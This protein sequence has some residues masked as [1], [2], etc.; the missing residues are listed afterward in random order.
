MPIN[1]PGAFNPDLQI[2]IWEVAFAKDTIPDD[3]FSFMSGTVNMAGGKK[4]P[5]LPNAIYLKINAEKPKGAYEITVPLVKSLSEDPGLGSDYDQ[6]D[7]EE[8]YKT[9]SWSIQYTDV[10]H[11]TVNQSY[12]HTALDTFPYDL[13]KERVPLLTE[14]FQQYRGKE[15][16]QA[17]IEGQSENLLEA[18]VYND[19]QLNPNWFLPNVLE[20]DQPVYDTNY[21]SFVN[22]ICNSLTAADIADD[23]SSISVEFL[24]KL[25][26]RAFNGLNGKNRIKPLKLPDGMD[27]YVLAVPYPQY[28][29]MMH[30]TRERSLG[31]IWR[32]SS[33]FENKDMWFPSAVGMVSRLLIVPNM[34]YPTLTPG[35]A[36]SQSGS[37]SGDH[38]TLSLA[39]RGMGDA[40][41]GSSD[42]RDFTAAAWQVGYLLGAQAL[43]EWMPEKFH[44][45]FEFEQ[46]DKY[47]GSGLFM[48]HGVK[49]PW[50]DAYSKNS[51]TIQ[52]MGSVVVPFA[53]PPLTSY[54]A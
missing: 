4:S 8:D 37:G 36:P 13:F 12:G 31:K 40:D 7:N 54:S 48:S 38:G 52:N 32:D 47:Y 23:N 11:A 15:S 2:K 24:Q 51:T 6:R 25:E 22:N 14:Y 20:G 49:A 42:P 41:D 16:Q 3:I 53:P 43:C 30:P 26:A 18:P 45:E 46:Y 28:M 39:Y 9:K 10:C 34:N 33:K 1:R 35:G 29:L 17:I 44:W 27:G 19:A 50:F 21:I 5:A